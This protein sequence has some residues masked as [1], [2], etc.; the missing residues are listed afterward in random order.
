MQL[1]FIF[2]FAVLFLSAV[3]GAVSGTEA[4]GEPAGQKEVRC[5]KGGKGGGGKGG[6]GGGF[7]GKKW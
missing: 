7:K 4:D 5:G 2:L 6:K 1:K 3:F